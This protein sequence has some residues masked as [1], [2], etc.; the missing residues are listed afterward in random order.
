MK[1][2]LHSGRPPARLDAARMRLHEIV[3]LR[4]KTW[5]PAETLERLRQAEGWR[6]GEVRVRHHIMKRFREDIQI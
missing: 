6:R 5:L 4:M 2:H 1:D 3:I